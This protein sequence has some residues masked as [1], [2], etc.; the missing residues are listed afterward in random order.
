MTQG[1]LNWYGSIGYPWLPIGD[2]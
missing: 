2:L 1:D